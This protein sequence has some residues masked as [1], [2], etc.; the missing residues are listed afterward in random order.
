MVDDKAILRPRVKV[1]DSRKV[2]FRELADPCPRSNI[3]LP[4]PYQCAAPEASHVDFES[5]QA[6]VIGGNRVVRKIAAQHLAEPPSLF[7]NRFVH[8]SP[9]FLFDGL[10][11]GSKPVS[12]GYPPKQKPAFPILTTN[13]SEA[14]EVERL[15]FACAAFCST[16]RRK[17][18]ELDQ[19]RL[20]R[21]QR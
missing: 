14:Q 17:A 11:T 1:D 13:V 15:R 7:W 6:R 12:S 10:Q 21:M 2:L 19:T 9:Q 20:L 4:A 5:L 18:A 16:L 3:F 8:S